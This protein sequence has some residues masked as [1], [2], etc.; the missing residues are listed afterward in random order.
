M[1]DAGQESATLKE[2][3]DSGPSGFG[4]L[5]R[6]WVA[7]WSSSGRWSSCLMEFWDHCL[8][9][10]PPHEGQSETGPQGPHR[11]T[12]LPRPRRGWPLRCPGAPADLV[13]SNHLQTLPPS[14]A[15]RAGMLVPVVCRLAWQRASPSSRVKVRAAQSSFRLSQLCGESGSSPS[16]LGSPGQQGLAHSLPLALDSPQRC[17]PGPLVSEWADGQAALGKLQ[18]QPAGGEPGAG[19]ASMQSWAPQI[20]RSW[21]CPAREGT[22]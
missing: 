11:Q 5:P 21:H 8:L 16:R 9:E 14:P 18:H 15:Q 12:P 13:P 22:L 4:V 20:V 7:L 19:Q 6:A 17:A 1:L 2:V 10:A 3:Y